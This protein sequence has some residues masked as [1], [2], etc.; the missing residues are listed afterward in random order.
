MHDRLLL[1]TPDLLSWLLL[2]LLLYASRLSLLLL[3]LL[4][5]LSS[6]SRLLLLL[7]HLGGEPLLLHLSRVPLLFLNSPVKISLDTTVVIN[8]AN[9][10]FCL[11]LVEMY[12]DQ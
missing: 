8:R 9:N 12:P 6:L 1:P 2:L 3:L 5:P 11:C 4:A 7:L 10:M